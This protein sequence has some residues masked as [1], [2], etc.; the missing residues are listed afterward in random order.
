MDHPEAIGE[1]LA[2]ADESALEDAYATYAPAVLAYVRRYVGADEA[3][4]V[5]QRTFLD[6]WRNARRYDPRQRFTGWLFTIAHR[7]AIDALRARRHHVVDVESIRDLVG[8]DGRR[9]WSVSPTLPTCGGGWGAFPTTSVRCWSWPTSPTCPSA[10]SPRASTY[11]W[12]RSRREPPAAPDASARS[13]VPST[14]HREE[15]TDDRAHARA[16]T[17]GQ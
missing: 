5:L 15:R 17:R 9:R 1:R 11:R 6:V 14:E 13:C 7:R 10:R 8:E 2:R 4:D 3:E 12:E 16:G